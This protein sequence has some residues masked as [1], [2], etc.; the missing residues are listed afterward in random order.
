MSYQTDLSQ[1]IRT[2]GLATLSVLGITQIV[3]AQ[4]PSGTTLRRQS[5]GWQ[6]TNK[7]TSSPPAQTAYF[8]EQGN[9]PNDRPAM[10][11]AGHA[12]PSGIAGM[13]A[14][15]DSSRMQ[16]TVTPPISPQ[17]QIAPPNLPTANL[18]GQNIYPP[19]GFQ[20]S[21]QGYANAQRYNLEQGHSNPQGYDNRAPSIQPPNYPPTNRQIPAQ[22]ASSELR[23]IQGANSLPR[24]V[25]PQPS[26]TG[27]REQGLPSGG[28]ANSGR[29]APDAFTSGLPFVTPAPQGRY[30]TSPYQPAIFQSSDYRPMAVPAQFVSN[31]TA[32]PQAYVAPQPMSPAN[33]TNSQAVVPPAAAATAPP[34]LTAQQATLPQFRYPQ[35]G[36]YSTAYQ[37]TP[38][39][40]TY[41]SA[42]A[43]PGAYIPPTLPPNLTPNLYTPNNSGYKPL[44]SLGQENY[45]VQLGRGIIGQ[46]TAYVAGQ[47]VRNFMRYLSP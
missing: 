46:P 3:L 44:F 27:L 9:P 43:V 28:Q 12:M 35:P 31:A 21:A 26:S 16:A 22:L 5:G 11:A 39:S 13:P 36:I 29:L 15:P 40:P 30:A 42:G 24:N 17:Q 14:F 10:P 45:N 32:A 37:C 25:A 8:Q 6:P 33:L 38:S 19:S 2:V 34:Y 20:G 4:Q 41:P 23:E 1:T 47:P 18:G 7:S